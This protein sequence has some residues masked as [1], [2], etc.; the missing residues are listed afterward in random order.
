MTSPASSTRASRTRRWLRRL[1]IGLGLGLVLLGIMTGVLLWSLDAP[2]IKWRVQ[3]MVR[4]LAGADIDYRATRVRLLSGL[5]VDDLV[6]LAPPRFRPAGP[7][8]LRASAVEVSW[9][10]RSLFGAGPK[11][12]DLILRGAEVTVV[13]DENGANS[14]S[15]LGT[16]KAAPAAPNKTPAP[17]APT[18][19]TAPHAPAAQAA[20]P[21]PLPMDLLGGG[22]PI[23]RVL[24][25][26][27]A[28]TLVRRER[29][30][31]IDRLQLTGLNLELDAERVGSGS[32]LRAKLGEAAAPLA[33]TLRRTPEGNPA[34]SAALR[35]WLSAAAS[36]QGAEAKL[37]VQVEHQSFA[38]GIHVARALHLEARLTQVPGK[39][40]LTLSRTE[41]VD[42][43]ATLEGSVELSGA[44][45]ARPLLRKARGDVDL[46]RL[47]LA[48]PPGL[49]PIAARKARLHFDIDQL[50]LDPLPR[51][52]A[53]GHLEIE[54]S[55]SGL[56][57]STASNTLALD[58][59]RLTL[60]AQPEPDGQLVVQLTAPMQGLRIDSPGRQ[61][62]STAA[63]LSGSGKVDRAGVLSG[64]LSLQVDSARHA[65][66]DVIALQQGR[67][68][69]L[70]GALRFD[71]AAPLAATGRV[72]LLGGMD[73]L[74]LA[75]SGLHLYAQGTRFSISSTL[76]GRAPFAVDVDLPI[77][78]LQLF[79]ADK[80]VL[81][82]GRTRLGLSLTELFPDTEQP[83]R[84]RAKANLS[85]ELGAA[86]AQIRLDKSADGLTFDL[87]ANASN[88]AAARPLLPASVGGSVPWEQLGLTLRSKGRVDR[89][90]AVA[91]QLDHKTEL[92]LT[93]PAFLCA[94]RTV[95]AEELALILGSHGTTRRHAGDADLRLRGLAVGKQVMGNAHLKLGF[96]LDADTPGLRVRVDG[97]TASGPEG[98]VNAALGLDKTAGGITYELDARLARLLVL[99]PLL[100]P[101]RSM[102]GFDLSNL[103]LGLRGR[104]LVTG[105]I[106]RTGP[107][108]T[109]RLVPRPLVTLGVN[110]NL[111]LS[112]KNLRWSEGDRA[113]ATPAATWRADLRSEGTRRSL[114]GDLQLGDLR[115]GFGQHQ[116][117][118]VRVQDSLDLVVTGDLEQGEGELTHDLRVGLLR[119]E[120]APGY[121]IGDLSIFLTARRRRDGLISVSQLRLQNP[122]GGTSLKLQGDLDF[123][124]ERRG[125][126]LR[127]TLEQQ[128]AKL[129]TV[130]PQYEGQGKASLSLSV[131]SGNLSLFRAKAALHLTEGTVRLPQRGISV[132]SVDGEVPISANLILDRRGLRL[133]RDAGANAYSELRFAD[134]HPLLDRRSY[135]SIAAISTPFFTV[136][137]L[138]GNI[139]IENNRVALSQIE[140]GLRGGWLTGQGLLSWGE[141]DSVLELRIRASNIKSSHGER[142]DGNA[143]VSVSTR[144]RSIDGRAEILRIGKRHLID[145][146]D[147]YDPHHADAAVNR[148]R[149]TLSYGY[150]DRVRLS[151]DHGF[152]S[153]RITFGGLAGMVRVDE[154]RGIPTGALIDKLLAQPPEPEP[155]SEKTP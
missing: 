67:A 19:P 41:L 88:L 113:V 17:T 42:G 14:L 91:P 62:S 135:L 23:R 15:E 112:A 107:G 9:S 80:R 31:P 12:N 27:A 103:A 37:D 94:G 26:R 7:E 153:A 3:A 45:G 101:L 90:A 155:E 132:E 105:L 58:Q 152:A 28:L 70:L 148:V 81:A 60:K 13:R 5:H 78:R 122:A 116:L 93:R 114:H 24:V 142:F 22:L 130:R 149:R 18:A 99:Q 46:V 10:L 4:E 121:S 109:P 50:V 139:A 30:R 137:P 68:Q 16:L 82:S 43:G 125:V 110:G 79:G 75:R 96:D 147:V 39:S 11:L 83:R 33:L 151:L 85:L 8:L 48:A 56:Q 20:P 21:P 134:Q 143:A 29:G 57:V 47:L 55:A 2:W 138:A 72:D 100:A 129:W 63:E 146:L 54:S 32:R 52:A 86:R 117:D 126:S 25:E 120:L 115:I 97:D 53:G 40:E 131:D 64:S 65:G 1:L 144:S 59:A 92:H 6:V 124:E 111:E 77:E 49:I 104:G 133:A 71:P 140:M 44:A 154:L 87:S 102:R 34:A 119:Q 95:A 51:L 61:L 118:V 150:P 38:P 145:L 76:G 136:K 36:P 106:E 127:G 69:L 74:E 84:T 73:A 141:K 98:T 108:R 123:S 35:L 128:L 89:I 66:T